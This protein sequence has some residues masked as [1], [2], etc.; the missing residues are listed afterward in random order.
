MN[1][2]EYADDEMMAISLANRLASDLRAALDLNDRVLFVVPGGTTPGPVFDVL[3]DAQLDWARVDVML[4]DERWVPEVH[5]RSNTRLLRERLLVGRAGAARYLPLYQRAESPEPV[6]EALC[7]AIRPALPIAVLLLG[8]GEDGHTASL[9]PG[10][11]GLETALAS[12][13][14]EL[15]AIRAPQVEDVRVTLPARILN[16]AM[17][18]HMVITGAAKRAML[19]RAQALQAPVVAVLNGM[20][21]HWSA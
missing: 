3:C 7:Q 18:K 4:S 16:D 6:L 1:L 19:E 12:D 2:I 9:F 20:T 8:M 17:A 14:P 5:V 13:A 10:A 21:V 15:V 11:Q